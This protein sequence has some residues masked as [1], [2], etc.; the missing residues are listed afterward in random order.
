MQFSK[1]E[2]SFTFLFI[3]IVIVELVSSSINSLSSLH[4]VAKPLILVSLILFFSINGA[5]L[6]RKTKLIMLFALVFSL[7]GDILL[8]FV[9]KS[10][11]FFLGGLVAFL[12]AHI[13]YILVFLEKRN[14]AEKPITF[15]IMLL[16]YTSG[17]FYILRDGLGDMLI[18]VIVY[19]LVILTMAITALLRKNSGDIIFANF[20][21][22]STSIDINVSWLN[23]EKVRKITIIA[24]KKMILYDE[25]NLEKPIKIYNNYA[26]YPKI[27]K[28][29]KSY[30]SK[31]AFVYK[32]KSRFIKFKDK[33]PLEKE[34]LSF[35][36][37]DVNLT[38]LTFAED[39]I[40]ITK[41]LKIV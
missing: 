39:I 33:M 2:K 32:G 36:K 15:I 4:Y 11:N 7:L 23:P 38:D 22:G 40:K 1:S 31:K 14:K 37:N 34:I 16:I 29:S 17:L 12:L 24:D 28:Y 9:D 25:M 10:S 35:I 19:I 18:P 13:M 30:F 3:A 41:K 20:A 6:T 21:S 8:M 5:H 26:S 27:S